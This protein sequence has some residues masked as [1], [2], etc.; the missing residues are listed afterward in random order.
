MIARA[1]SA[2]KFQTTPTI[3]QTA[4]IFERSTLLR[5]DFL[6]K[7]TNSKSSTA[8][9]AAAQ[10][11][12][13]A[14]LS[15]E[16]LYYNNTRLEMK[17]LSPLPRILGGLQPPQPPGSYAYVCELVDSNRMESIQRGHGPWC[18]LQTPSPLSFLHLHWYVVAI[19]AA[20]QCKCIYSIK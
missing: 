12:I 16:S 18:I 14:Q 10:S 3:G 4:P 17:G 6:H 20:L 2:L 7:R 8:N 19:I 13:D 1:R 11:Q 5:L 9:L 15:L